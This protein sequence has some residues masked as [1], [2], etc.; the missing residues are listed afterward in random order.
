MY[1]RQVIDSLNKEAVNPVKA[2]YYEHYSRRHKILSEIE[3]LDQDQSQRT[4]EI[5]LLSY[6]IDEIEKANLAPGEEEALR[7]ELLS[8]IHI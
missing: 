6:Q 8:L 4:R 3:K 5:D 1:K 7:Q 2:R